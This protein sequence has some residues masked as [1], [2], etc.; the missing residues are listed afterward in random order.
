MYST[1]R[2][3]SALLVFS[4]L[5]ACAKQE[6]SGTTQATSGASQA[7]ATSKGANGASSKSGSKRPSSVIT[8]TVASSVF[9]DETEALGTA[10]SNES[11]DITAKATNRV[12]AIHFREG[13]YVKKDA[14]I[15]ELDGAEARA[16]LAQTQASL[17]DTESQYQ[18]SRELYQTKVLSESDLIQLEAKM[19][20]SK[21]QVAAAESRLSD[22]IIRAPFAGRVGLRNVSVGS[23]VTPGQIMTTLDDINVIKLDFTVPENYLATVKEGQHVEAKTSAYLNKT[24]RGR[25]SSI[26]TRVD[27]VS[28]SAVVRALIDN[29]DQQLKPGM[30]MT[31]HLTRSQSNV[32]LVPEQALMPDGDKQF[33]YVVKN[34]KAIK[35]AVLIGRRKP[36]QVE[37]RQGLSAGDE[38]VIEGGEKLTDGAQVSVVSGDRSAEP[39]S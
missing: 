11:V 7:A 22:T 8:V 24:F 13:E 19:L 9:T 1:T 15:V 4:V 10:K 25:V 20:S 18:R 28:R 2:A 23:L 21:A 30:F 39:R 5:G 33:V 16:N 38:V 36:G 29:R 17:R 3:L 34:S 14:V 27:P 35:T 37:V 26:A 32:L 31:V 12:V 6:Q